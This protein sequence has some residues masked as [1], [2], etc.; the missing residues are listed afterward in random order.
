MDFFFNCELLC[1][2]MMWCFNCCCCC[3]VF[4]DAGCFWNCICTASVSSIFCA[5]HFHFSTF[6]VFIFSFSFSIALS[7]MDVLPL[8]NCILRSISCAEQK[9]HAILLACCVS[10]I[11]RVNECY[12]NNIITACTNHSILFSHFYM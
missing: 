12:S 3:L 1:W 2:L 7:R 11:V 10:S 4:V 9:Q 8:S 6:I 5:I